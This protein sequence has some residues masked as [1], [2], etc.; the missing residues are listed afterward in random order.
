MSTYSVVVAAAVLWSFGAHT[1]GQDPAKA[2]GGRPLA[3]GQ[4]KTE[5]ASPSHYSA[6]HRA[7]LASYNPLPRQTETP[8]WVPGQIIV[9]YNYLDADKGPVRG[10]KI[11]QRQEEAVEIISQAYGLRLRTPHVS[12]SFRPVHPSLIAR[13]GKKDKTELEV[14]QA[15]LNKRAA[16][17][18]ALANRGGQLN[19]DYGFS[20]TVLI[21]LDP[22]V[23]I[24]E[25]IRRMQDP[26]PLA[27]TSTV[28][29]AV[30]P[31]YIYQ[32]SWV[33]ND[34][35]FSEQWALNNTGQ[36]GGTV[37]ADID[38]PEAWDITQGNAD[39][40]VAVID[41]GVDY[42]HEDLAANI[43][44]NN[45]ETPDNDT[46]DDGNG[47]VDDYL[48]W[49]FVE[50][51]G[52]CA[53]TEDCSVRDNDPADAHGHG[54]HCSGIVAA[55][56]NNG[57]GIAGLA[58]NTKVMALRAGYL[59]VDGRGSLYDSDIEPAI[60]YAVGNGADVISMSFGGGGGAT[61]DEFQ[62]AFDQGVVLVAAAGNANTHHKTYPAAYD[63]VVAVSAS[64][65]D[66]AK[67]S[68]SNYG[69][70]V[71]VVAP[72]VSIL[73][74]LPGDAYTSWNGTSMACPHVAGLG[75]LLLSQTPGLSQLELKTLVRSTTD[76]VT[77]TEYL[78]IGRIN[79]NEALSRPSTLVADLDSSL[80]DTTVGATIDILGTANG[81]G[82][83][84]YTLYFG[85]GV[86]PDAWT[87]ISTSAVPVTDGILGSWDTSEGTD[88][89]YSIRLVAEDSLA[90]QSEDRVI[91]TTDNVYIS[92]PWGNDIFRSG[93]TITLSGTVRG[94]SFQSYLVDWGVGEN[95]VDWFNTGVTLTDDGHSQ[96]IDG[97]LALWDTSV[98]TDAT[99]VTFRLTASFSSYQT[100]EKLMIYLDPTLKE[101][102]PVLLEAP[103]DEERDEPMAM[104]LFQPNVADLNHDCY[105]E[106]IV[107]R[108]GNP[109]TL[110]VFDHT[111]TPLPD[112]P[113]AIDPNGGRDDRLPFPVIADLNNDGYDEIVL[114]R[115]RS[116][117]GNC[118]N[119][120]VILVYDYHG[121]LLDSFPVLFPDWCNAFSSG[122]QQL[123]LADLDGNGVLEIIIVSEGAA[124]V[125]DDHGNTFNGWPKELIGW[126][127]GTHEGTPSVGNLDDDSDLE[128]IIAVDWAPVLNEPTEYTGRVY[129][130]N[131]D[132]SAVPGWPV[133]TKGYSFS[134][135]S[136]GDIDGDGE[137]E[138]AV[139]FL[140]WDNRPEEYGIYVYDRNGDIAPGWPQLQGYE[141]WSNPV[142]ADFDADGLLEI[143]VSALFAGTYV[144]RGDGSIVD[145]WPQ[146]M[147]WNDYYSPVV[148]D[149]T[150]DGVPDVI[151]N[152]NYL[153]GDCSVYAWESQGGLIDGFPKVTGA[154]VGAPTIVA[155]I[156]DD[157]YVELLATSNTRE[158][159]GREMHQG[160]IYVWELEGAE[161]PTTMHWPVFQ[162]DR[163]H[164]GWYMRP[165]DCNENRIGDDEDISGGASDDC[166]GNSVPD[167]C[168][169]LVYC[170]SGDCNKNDV[171]DEC[172]IAGG[173][174]DDNVNG[175][176][177]ECE[178]VPP[179][180][181]TGA[182]HQA[183]KHRYISIDQSVNGV[184][185]IAYKIELVEMLRCAG[186]LRRTCSVDAD[187]PGVCDNDSDIT[188]SGDAGCALVGG[189]CVV[190]TPCVHHPDEGLSWWVQ[191][192]VQEPLGCRLPG[193]CT[194]ED[195]FA[196]LDT[197]AHF[198]TW[199]DFGVADSSLLHISDCQITPV[200][201]YAVSA[202]APPTGD[203]CSA[204]L[205]IGTI[206]RPPP[207]NYGDVVGPVDPVTI[208]FDP[209]NQILSVGDISGYLLTNLNYG[210]P[211]DPK[212]QAHW[213]WVDMEGQGAPY[214][215]P[216]GILNVSDL[217]QILFGLEGRPYSWAGNNVDPG[218][219]P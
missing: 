159:G 177:D 82:F 4:L 209:P 51:A 28:I 169:I 40:V 152:T 188:C 186:D 77:S 58:P 55:P 54:T 97:T 191:T 84:D 197:T 78:G 117:D 20:R 9:K 85:S 162:H 168:D 65:H 37:D 147:C 31:N 131:L 56:A 187:C 124:T 134:S 121:E 32:T 57:T 1:G 11:R 27:N 141:V 22:R 112:F 17:K 198:Q 24:R 208:E 47:F 53:E 103:Y 202:C 50:N 148:G 123:A 219:C 155:D 105:K 69:S 96:V 106:I 144:F 151:T 199:N 174:A 52:G 173:A 111:G 29:E 44:T 118:D 149:I 108:A 95:P 14:L 104:G 67:A 64:D 195:W 2:G 218:D 178:L 45:G 129:A 62:F 21:E 25:T 99:F 163:Q 133:T 81:T 120:P 122:M 193:G 189:T 182:R 158:S 175:I 8:D 43:W 200:A 205:V 107:S 179:E 216:Q 183:R 60:L 75:A 181:P 42:N 16:K 165:P 142:L 180:L 83:V 15:Q 49:D 90:Q 135:P 41:T 204:P 201:T 217:N 36:T 171:P 164:T 210:L 33:P 70:W 206:L 157:G 87:L 211:G 215:R 115:P 139:G 138:I 72:G 19:K 172:D 185:E 10:S 160:G 154:S 3:D 110:H 59:T 80:D 176:P 101:G 66:D 79:A 86:Y 88:G 5:R 34:P 136:I 213:T 119:P 35:R 71:D 128:I 207:G 190:T 212:P 145:G 92:Y 184:F 98:L 76:T 73:S 114:H 94:S 161:D 74:T 150:G 23:R 170:S 102:W 132:G 91:L 12:E 116:W 126:V 89:I 166:N 125:L 39:V 137:N 7:V 100:T 6:N 26:Q 68:F 38:A 48:G 93:A 127:G 153:Y 146:S 63:Q 203:V 18:P 196:R 13:M 140:D 130:Y 46:D 156:D 194:D 143:V 192:P 109:P 214:Y 61:E 167:E 113:V 30:H